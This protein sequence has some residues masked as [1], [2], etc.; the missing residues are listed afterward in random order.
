MYSNVLTECVGFGDSSKYIPTSF[1]KDIYLTIYYNIK[2]SIHN[3]L[4]E[5]P[6]MRYMKI[7]VYS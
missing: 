2:I 7:L 3:K 6:Q 5:P 4:Q 1:R